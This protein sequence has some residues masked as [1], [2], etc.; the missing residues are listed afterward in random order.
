[1]SKRGTV[2]NEAR[3]GARPTV[4][5]PPESESEVPE[6]QRLSRSP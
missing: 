4:T 1:M 6:L 5:V 3:D 2:D